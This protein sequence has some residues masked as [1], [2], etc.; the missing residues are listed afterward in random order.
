MFI[1]IDVGGTNTRVVGADNL[2]TPAFLGEPIRRQ[3]TQNFE[4]D[5]TFIIQTAQNI[6]GDEQIDAVGIGAAGTPNREKTGVATARNLISWVGKPLVASLSH[7]LGGCPV[8]YETD[9]TAA[10]LGEAYYGPTEGDFDYI[11]WGTGIGGA[12]IRYTDGSPTASVLNWRTHFEGWIA[13]VGGAELAQRYGKAP[14]SFTDAEWSDVTGDFR[15]HLKDYIETIAPQAIVF[16]GGLAVRHQ[17][18]IE[19]IGSEIDSHLHVTSFGNDSGL[20]GGFGLV[21]HSGEFA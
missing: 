9:V 20:V 3:N 15:R 17:V 16:G 11:T 1:S 13:D 8:Y 5:I 21:R 6:A 12:A 4:Q 14:E 7:G 18:V 10:G 2:A 19:D